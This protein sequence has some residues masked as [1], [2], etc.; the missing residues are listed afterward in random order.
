MMYNALMTYKTLIIEEPL[1]H[2]TLVTI[3][4]PKVRNAINIDMMKDLLHFWEST[5]ENQYIRCII[6]TGTPPAFCAGADLKVRKD[7][8]I[9]TWLQQ[10][11][12]LR[13]AMRTMLYCPA[14]IIAAVNGAA[15]GGGL[16]L[17][18]AADFAYANDTAIFAQSETKLGIIP[19]A[20][21]TQNLPR[22]CGTRRA[23]ELCFTGKPFTAKEALQWGIINKVCSK[24]NLLKEALKTAK[25]IITNGPIA[26]R[27]A[28]KA[29]N[30]AFDFDIQEGY[31]VELKFYYEAI[32]TEDRVEGINAFNEKRPPKFTGK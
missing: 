24:K 3:N 22:A 20:M 16:E 23:K 27:L 13:R 17:A 15:F 5:L 6:L 4:R 28:K 10:H 2:I 32:A 31:N 30:V 7:M 9:N 12:V 8:D 1:E 21:G 25:T 26:N 29:M 11:N 18:L 19:G 14:P